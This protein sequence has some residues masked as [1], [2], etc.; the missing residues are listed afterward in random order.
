MVFFKLEIG[1]FIFWIFHPQK[2]QNYRN[3]LCLG[4]NFMFGDEGQNLRQIE[5]PDPKDGK[6]VLCGKQFSNMQNARRHVREMHG[7]EKRSFD[8]QLCGMVFTRQR[9][10]KEHMT[11]FHHWCGSTHLLSPNPRSNK[12]TNKQKFSWWF[13]RHDQPFWNLWRFGPG[14]DSRWRWRQSGN[15]MFTLRKNICYCW[16]KSSALSRSSCTILQNR[17]PVL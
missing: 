15:Q 2:I 7:G 12:Q 5:L 1:R 3:W 11:R 10:F 13:C 16:I 4:Y 8:C 6:C 14:P 9:N 17:M